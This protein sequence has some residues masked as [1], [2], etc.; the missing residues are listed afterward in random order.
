MTARARVA[1][2]GAAREG[3]AGELVS[4]LYG[5]YADVNEVAL[6]PLPEMLSTGAP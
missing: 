2:V 1:I 4:V 3:S 5:P 6:D